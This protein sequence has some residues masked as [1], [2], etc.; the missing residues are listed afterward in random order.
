MDRHDDTTRTDDGRIDRSGEGAFG[1]PAPGSEGNITVRTTQRD[2]YLRSL[3]TEEEG[4]APPGD[5]GTGTGEPDDRNK[6]AHEEQLR[7]QRA[8][9]DDER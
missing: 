8:V 6:Q 9:Q 2:R 5:D 1:R 7:L 4:Y 3:G